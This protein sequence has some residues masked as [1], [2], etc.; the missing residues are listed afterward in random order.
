MV[1][2]FQGVN[3]SNFGLYLMALVLE[4][5]GLVLVLTAMGDAS[6]LEVVRLGLQLKR[7]QVQSSR[8]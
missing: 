7:P 6:V 4:S 1:S 2:G 5:I 3:I 8:L